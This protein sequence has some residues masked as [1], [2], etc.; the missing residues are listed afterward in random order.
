MLYTVNFDE[1]VFFNF[2][3][4]ITHIHVY[5]WLHAF[6][7]LYVSSGQ[8]DLDQTYPISISDDLREEALHDLLERIEIRE[9]LMSPNPW[10]GR[11]TKLQ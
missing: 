3:S 5:I 7:Y 8:P 11:E 1:P 2:G 6:Q 9:G 10:S 4:T